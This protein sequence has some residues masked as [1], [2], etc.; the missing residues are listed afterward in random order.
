[1]IPFTDVFIFECLLIHW[2][3]KENLQSFS[4]ILCRVSFVNKWK[5]GWM[6]FTEWIW[7]KPKI[8]NRFQNANGILSFKM[9]LVAMHSNQN[10]KLKSS[11]FQSLLARIFQLVKL[12][13]PCFITFEFNIDK[14]I[15]VYQIKTSSELE[16]R[17][18]IYSK[19]FS[20]RAKIMYLQNLFRWSSSVS[21]V[22]NNDYFTISTQMHV[23]FN[24]VHLH[25]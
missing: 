25:V 15:L 7:R 22:V 8:L 9:P 19:S 12:L 5:C 24:A 3:S 18:S 23:E 6:N 13:Y 1:M 17:I 10:W 11:Y 20:I 4:C 16:F 21:F 14:T 2:W